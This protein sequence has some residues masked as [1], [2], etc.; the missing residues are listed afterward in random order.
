MSTHAGLTEKVKAVSTTISSRGSTPRGGAP[1]KQSSSSTGTSTNK[2]QAG[3]KVGTFS[4]GGLG[5]GRRND[6]NTV[7]LRTCTSHQ[8]LRS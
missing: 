4:L 5:A 8:T 2:K 6:A 7:S 3:P 1:R